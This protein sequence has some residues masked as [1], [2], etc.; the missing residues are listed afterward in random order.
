MQFGLHNDSGMRDRKRDSNSGVLVCVSSVS[1]RNSLVLASVV[2][3]SIQPINI[4]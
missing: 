4:E 3:S 2:V 1:V